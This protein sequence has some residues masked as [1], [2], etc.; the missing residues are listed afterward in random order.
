MGESCQ[1]LHRWQLDDSVCFSIME[2]NGAVSLVCVTAELREHWTVIGEKER[3]VQWQVC[4]S[5][6]DYSVTE[7]STN[8]VIFHLSSCNSFLLGILIKRFRILRWVFEKNTHL[9]RTFRL[10][11][12]GL[13]YLLLLN[14]RNFERLGLKIIYVLLHDMRVV[15]NKQAKKTITR[16]ILDK[17]WSYIIVRNIWKAKHYRK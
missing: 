11:K 8:C 12:W 4:P 17:T 5:A 15:N 10:Q 9:S 1:Y 2:G 3:R 13:H 16:F 6:A 7:K 14:I